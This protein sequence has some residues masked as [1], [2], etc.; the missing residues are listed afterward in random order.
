MRNRSSK[1]SAPLGP[2]VWVVRLDDGF[3]VKEEHGEPLVPPV[4]QRTAIKIARLIA[5]ANR[6]EL[7]VQ[8]RDGRIRARD[9]HGADPFPPRG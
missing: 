7:I 3:S 4:S 8:G 6:S 9:S 2:N 1:Q 5:Q